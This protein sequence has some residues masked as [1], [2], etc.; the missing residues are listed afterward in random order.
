MLTENEEKS[1]STAN[2]RQANS[3]YADISIFALIRRDGK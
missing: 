1:E 2:S 3:L